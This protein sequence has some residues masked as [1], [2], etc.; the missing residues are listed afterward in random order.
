MATDTKLTGRTRRENGTGAARQMRREGWLPCIIYGGSDGNR[1][2][3][4]KAHDMELLLQHHRGESMMVDLVVDDEQP[5]KVLLKEVQHHPVSE[6]VLHADFMEVSLTEKMRVQVPLVLTGECL[7]VTQDG[8]VLDH[9][10][11][12]LEVECL[13]GDIPESIEADVTNL[14]LGDSFLVRDLVLPP[15]IEAVV[16][17]DLAV[18]SVHAQRVEEEPEAEAEAEA[19]GAEPELVGKEEDEEKSSED[20]EG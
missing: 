17:E 12:E 16:E 13:P 9:T 20:E 18:A 19:E 8:G 2:I 14:R 6:D 11:H 10:L 7:V 5:R 1:M 3:Q 15:G 4:V